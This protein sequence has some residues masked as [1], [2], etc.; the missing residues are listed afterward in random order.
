[1][2]HP[3]RNE[4]HGG[5]AS[6][7]VVVGR[8]VLCVFTRR[9]NAVVTTDTGAFRGGVIHPEDG[10]EVVTRVTEDAT[11]VAEETEYQVVREVRQEA[12]VA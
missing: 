12:A 8:N 5:M 11:V 7:A 9:G 3:C 10:R 2:L 4:R 1:M 6:R